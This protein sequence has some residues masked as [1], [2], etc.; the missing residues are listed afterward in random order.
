MK[1]YVEA[2]SCLLLTYSVWGVTAIWHIG[3]ATFYSRYSSE[4]GNSGKETGGVEAMKYRE[5]KEFISP[6]FDFSLVGGGQ[7]SRV[8]TVCPDR[9]LTTP[10]CPRA[11][12]PK[13]QRVS[14]ATRV[15]AARV[16]GYFPV[17]VISAAHHREP[18][19]KGQ[20]I[21]TCHE[22]HLWIFFYKFE[23]NRK[24]CK[25]F[26]C[27]ARETVTFTYEEQRLADF[28]FFMAFSLP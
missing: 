1:K 11:S 17:T 21:C 8:G 5:N 2:C 15:R 9:A 20:T 24:S 6:C 26:F 13:A 23:Q 28:S 22:S 7:C 25:R 4:K 12:L 19:I 16:M 18:V 10:S 14:A 3:Y 27:Y